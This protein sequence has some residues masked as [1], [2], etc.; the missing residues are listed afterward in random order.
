M[1]RVG[2]WA[3]RAMRSRSTVATIAQGSV[4][5]MSNRMSTMPVAMSQV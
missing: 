3:V 4:M 2:G 5:G 1:V